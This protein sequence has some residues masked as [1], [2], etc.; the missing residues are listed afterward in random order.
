[1]EGLINNYKEGRFR[2][3]LTGSGE[4]GGKT[5]PRPDWLWPPLTAK[6]KAGWEARRQCRRSVGLL[7]ASGATCGAGDHAGKKRSDRALMGNYPT[8]FRTYASQYATANR[9]SIRSPKAM[10]VNTGRLQGDSRGAGGLAAD[11]MTKNWWACRLHPAPWK[12]CM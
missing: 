2:H 11:G 7:P 8:R 3:P 5:S 1:V 12:G 6:E 9:G 4:G 10:I